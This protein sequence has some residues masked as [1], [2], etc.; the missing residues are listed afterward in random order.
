MTEHTREDEKLPIRSRTIMISNIMKLT[1]KAGASPA[2]LKCRAENSLVMG[3]PE[4][5]IV[6]RLTS[7]GSWV[8]MVGL[9][10]ILDSKSARCPLNLGLN[11]TIISEAKI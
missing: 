3:E 6:N 11:F 1:N 9:I 10:T 4:D 8:G 2:S 7:I 5:L